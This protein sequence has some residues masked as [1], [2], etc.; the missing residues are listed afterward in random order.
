MIER[1]GKGNM[2]CELWVRELSWEGQ[3]D[4]REIWTRQNMIDEVF[5]LYQSI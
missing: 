2:I 4:L 1:Y 5:M 3:Y